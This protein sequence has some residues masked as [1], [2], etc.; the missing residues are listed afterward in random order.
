MSLEVPFN[1]S[2]LSKGKSW[3]NSV[4]NLSRKVLKDATETGKTTQE[5]SIALADER[6]RMVNPIYG[7]RSLDIIKSLVHKDPVWKEMVQARQ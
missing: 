6:S 5:I 7:H 2:T 4:Y 1:Y 3:D